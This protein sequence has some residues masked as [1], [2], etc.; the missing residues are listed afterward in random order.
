MVTK[1]E[2]SKHLLRTSMLS[3]CPP[4]RLVFA[5]DKPDVREIDVSKYS[6]AIFPREHGQLIEMNRL[7]Y[8]VV[9]RYPSR[10]H[11]MQMAAFYNASEAI[12]VIANDP[13]G[14]ITDWILTPKKKLSIKYYTS[15]R[16]TLIIKAEPTL[17]NIG[18]VYRQ[19]A[20]KQFW[21]MPLREKKVIDFFSVASMSGLEL[22]KNHFRNFRKHIDGNIG[23]W[24]TQWRR[25]PFDKMYPDYGAKNQAAFRAYINYLGKN[26]ALAMPYVNSMLVDIDNRN[27]LDFSNSVLLKSESGFSVSYNETMK[28]L[29]YACPG[30]DAWVNFISAVSLGSCQGIDVT[31]HGVYLDMLA[32]AKPELC[33]SS[34]HGH[35]PGD[36]LVWQMG[37]LKLLRKMRGVVMAEGCAEIYI[38]SLDYC[39]AHLHTQMADSIPLWN[40][41]YGDLEKVV[42][43][44]L[45]SDIRKKDF[46]V[47]QTRLKK[48]GIKSRYGSPWMV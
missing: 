41:V 12:I 28:N 16:E 45:P 30:S 44:K 27:L 2:F 40:H 39:L 22:E 31:N 7:T 24:F 3:L 20:D 15:G 23:V 32:A 35:A 47:E 14:A 17:S 13:A 38:N 34:D 11:C 33:W 48:F 25:F 9:R 19:W 42:G 36:P 5:G 29:C 26:S 10:D 1:R 37:L 21:M 18:K 6:H 8:P 46:Q 4:M 43:W